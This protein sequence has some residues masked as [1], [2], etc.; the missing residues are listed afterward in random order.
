MEAT[1]IY[2]MSLSLYDRLEAAGL[3]VVL[4]EPRSVKQVPGEEPAAVLLK[5][6]KTVLAFAVMVP[7]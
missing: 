6:V 4:V 5:N 7:L 1:G 2:W 3:E